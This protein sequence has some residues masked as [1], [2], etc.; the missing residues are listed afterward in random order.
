MGY[1][2]LNRFKIF[3]NIKFYLGFLQIILYVKI[4]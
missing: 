1:I 2:I 4:L 3:L